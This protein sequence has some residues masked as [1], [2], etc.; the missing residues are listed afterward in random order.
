VSV[1]CAMN[2]L[3]KNNHNFIRKKVVRLSLFLVRSSACETFAVC[4]CLESTI[5]PCL[6]ARFPGAFTLFFLTFS[7]FAFHFGCASTVGFVD[8]CSFALV[9]A[10][11]SPREQREAA[12]QDDAAMRGAQETLSVAG[13]MAALQRE[14]RAMQQLGAASSLSS[15]SSSS[16][17]LSAAA[18]AKQGGLFD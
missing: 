7:P 8:G 9:H 12:V 18:K 11:Y 5:A 17:S 16:S 3:P 6:A 14:Q 10:L 13:L 2:I 1:R 15:S 4:T